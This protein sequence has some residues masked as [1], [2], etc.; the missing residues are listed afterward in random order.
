MAVTGPR[1]GMPRP[2]S[3]P[4]RPSEDEIR[5]TRELTAWHREWVAKWADR[6]GFHPEEHPKADS[7]YNLHHVDLDAPQEALDEYHRR[8]DEIMGRTPPR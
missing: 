7:D 2:R 4:I 6:A 5:R 3:Q 1:P 8:A